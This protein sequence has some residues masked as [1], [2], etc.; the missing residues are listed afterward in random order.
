[1]QGVCGLCLSRPVLL[2]SIQLW[3]NLAMNK[4]WGKLL[5]RTITKL[6][7]CNLHGLESTRFDNL[8]TADLGGELHRFSGLS[9]KGAPVFAIGP[10][11]MCYVVGQFMQHDNLAYVG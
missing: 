3:N 4:V 7:E 5:R 8:L 1:M 6:V 10:A 2:Q 11:M 9:F